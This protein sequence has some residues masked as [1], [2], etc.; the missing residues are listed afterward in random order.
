MDLLRL[1]LERAGTADEGLAVLTDLLERHGQ[2]GRTSATV[3]TS[4]H[5]S[6]IL[7]DASGAW[8]LETA[9]RH[10]AAKKVEDWAA[11]SNVYTIGMDFD[12]ISDSAI[13]FAAKSGWFDP[14]SGLPFDFAAAY[15]DQGVPFLPGCAARLVASRHRLKTLEGQ[16]RLALED[17]FSVLR[18]HGLDDTDPDW[19]PGADGDSLVCMHATAPAESETAASVVVELPGKSQPAGASLFW[20]SLASPCLSSFIPLWLDSGLP[21][22]WSQPDEGRPDAWWDLEAMQR[23]IERDY[24]RLSAAPRA[25][26]A[27]LEADTLAA[28]RALAPDAGHAVRRDLMH[29]F[30]ARQEAACRIISDLTAA[31]AAKVLT[32]R[33]ADPRGRYLADVAAAREETFKGREART[34]LKSVPAAD[35]PKATAAAR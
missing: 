34:S 19:R 12:R 30:A 1:T 10:W 24:G 25:I 18:G 5:N 33:D 3:E 6:F 32:P 28:V 23:L 13:A 31:C 22:H 11:I 9:G 14:A 21:V 8:I 16:G 17:V 7:A 2:S 20:A 15:A 26:L 27:Q 4:Y 35:P 29:R